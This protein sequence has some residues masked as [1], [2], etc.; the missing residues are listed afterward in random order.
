MDKKRPD[1]FL[2]ICVTALVAVG[3]VMVFSAT[4]TQSLR[5]GNPFMYLIKQSLYVALGFIAM[6]A[7]YR[8]DY[9][10]YRKW[11]AWIMGGSLFLLAVV[12]LP[13]IGHSAG[14]ASRWIDLGFISF[15]PSE[16]AKIAVVIYLA[17][18][19]AR[20]GAVIREFIK[21]LFPPLLV[22]GGFCFIVLI[23]PD[24]GTVFVIFGT[25]FIMFYLAGAKAVH[26]SLLFAGGVAA[27]LLSSFVSSYRW[28]RIITFIDP[29]K[30]PRGA[31]FHIIQSM[32]AVG[33]GGFMGLGL[34][35]SRQKFL[36]LPEQY[37]D[38]IYAILCEEGGFL[39]A[40]GV[41]LLFIWFIGRGLKICRQCP[42]RFG[43]LLAGGLTS[44]IALEAVVNMGVVVDLIP[45]T[46]VPLPFISYG[47][48]SLIVMMFTVG[49]LLNIS[50]FR[51]RA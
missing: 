32:I 31:G 1:I 24:L 18:V 40:L 45:T 3:L 50:S 12:F 29:W 34:G 43:M 38:F 5:A 14:G 21:G 49:I 46:G 48:T 30:D 7:G 13:M 23:Q 39:G 36:Y 15:Q 35:A 26:L 11:T 47:G 20:K 9:D 51:E 6:Y 37:T 41:I 10:N 27:F 16:L 17:D 33:S 19:L 42:D 25:A 2:L 28:Q 22:V 8:I 44:F 4:T